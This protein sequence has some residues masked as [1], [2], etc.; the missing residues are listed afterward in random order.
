MPEEQLI[1]ILARLAQAGDLSARTQL[2]ERLLVPGR[3]EHKL[4][5][6]AR[7]AGA[8]GRRKK[9]AANFCTLWPRR[10]GP[11]SCPR[12]A[13]FDPE[14][15]VG[16]ALFRGVIADPQA[17]AAARELAC[18]GAGGGRAGAGCACCCRFWAQMRRPP[19]R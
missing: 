6:A 7:Q 3:R 11:I 14:D 13:S 18:E 10:L 19:T 8:A 15:P 16:L 1:R 9:K 5:T 17:T 4:L 12:R 2:R